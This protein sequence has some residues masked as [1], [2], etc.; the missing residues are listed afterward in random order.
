MILRQSLNWRLG[1]GKKKSTVSMKSVL[2]TL[3]PWLNPT[4]SFSSQWGGLFPSQCICCRCCMQPRTRKFFSILANIFSNTLIFSVTRDLFIYFPDSQHISYQPLFQYYSL[5][6]VQLELRDLVQHYSLQLIVRSPAFMLLS[7]LSSPRHAS[8][9]VI[10]SKQD[11]PD[12]TYEAAVKPI[13][14]SCV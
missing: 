13:Q 9:N 8:P 6:I 12:F 14:L 2:A 1:L 11:Q 4:Q 3:S 10:V 5:A 7:Y